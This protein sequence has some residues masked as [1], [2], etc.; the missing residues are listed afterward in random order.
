MMGVRIEC[1]ELVNRSVID[2]IP[3]INIKNVHMA[4]E[5]R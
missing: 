2:K 5:F 3:K 1:D 4:A